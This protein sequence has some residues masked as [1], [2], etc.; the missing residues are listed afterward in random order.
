[1]S[2]LFHFEKDVSALS[3]LSIVV[4][5]AVIK[6]LARY[7]LSD[8]LCVKWPNDILYDGKKMAGILIDIQAETHGVCQ[9]IIGIG[10]NVNMRKDKEQE[11]TQPWTS[12]LKILG[13]SVDR[14]VLCAEL[15]NQLIEYVQ[16]FNKSGLAAFHQE[17]LAIDGL[18]NSKL[19]LDNFKQRISG[20]AKGINDQGHLLLQLPSGKVEAFSAGDVTIVK[21]H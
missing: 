20:I 21:N 3:G 19:S 4:G 7:P 17:W 10:L 15:I 12:L 18:I 14:N 6:A 9:A 16:R 8:K 5:L 13:T 1:L 2:C 11:I